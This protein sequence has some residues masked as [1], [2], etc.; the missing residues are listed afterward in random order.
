M[1]AGV[2]K[3]RGVTFRSLGP[4]DEREIVALWQACAGDAYPLR[5]RLWRQITADNPD[6]QPGDVL[7]AVAD[8]GEPGPGSPTPLGPIV[9]FGYLGRSR[10][11]VRGRRAWAHEGWLQVVAVTP[12]RQREGIGRAIVERLV[13]EAR[14]DGIK[15]VRLG[16]GI[17]YLLPGVPVDLLGAQPFFEALGAEFAD[18]VYDVRADVDGRATA[19]PE[20]TALAEAGLTVR[21]MDPM[22]GEALLAFLDR[23]FEL[24]WVYDMGWALD[25][26]MAAD[27]VLLLLPEDVPGGPVA[28]DAMRGFAMLHQRGDR[29]LFGP[30]FWEGLLGP[31]SGGLGPIGVVEGLR[32]RGVGRALLATGL[33]TL[34]ARGVRDCVIDWTVLLDFYGAFGFQPWKAYIQGELPE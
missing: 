31:S 20:R 8:P 5:A 23:E 24:D 21:P 29:P 6:F 25:H 7:V 14:A 28:A 34:H 13:G 4:D 18:K 19:D 30:R 17:H 33:D 3:L 32:G 10:S 11:L 22:E 2:T 27:D 15:R 16:G 26:G 1:M 9:G 12:G